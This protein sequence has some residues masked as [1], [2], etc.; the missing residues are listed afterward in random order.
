MNDLG[1]P[2]ERIPADK[3]EIVFHQGESFG[4][5]FDEDGDL[6]HEVKIRIDRVNFSTESVRGTPSPVDDFLRQYAD[7]IEKKIRRDYFR[8]IDPED[9]L[10]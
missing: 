1:R 8:G 10:K 4:E 9:P 2:I 3:I 7:D 6:V 5:H